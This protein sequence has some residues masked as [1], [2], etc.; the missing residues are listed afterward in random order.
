[1]I[2]WDNF[3]ENDEVLKLLNQHSVEQDYL[4][5]KEVIDFN[6]IQKIYDQCCGMGRW[7]LFL[8]NNKK[9]VWGCDLSNKSISFVKENS[10]HPERYFIKNVLDYKPSIEYDLV[11]NYYSS[12]GSLP[13]KKDNM[14]MLTK[15]IEVLASNGYL[16]LE[17]IN[18]D[19]IINNFKSKIE[20]DNI[21]R[22]SQIEND[23]LH[24]KWI[25]GKKEYDTTMLM[26]NK[27]DVIVFLQKK[28]LDVIYSEVTD[29]NLII[30]QKKN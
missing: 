16:V 4:K 28:G 21:I 19:Y 25:I 9:D 29:R 13:T 1:M 17:F 15:A 7:S 12:F 30:F 20:Y 27:D 2:L 10:A 3:Y 14:K 24:Q 11:I 26:I 8:E 6:N 18:K 23:K 5:I 22:K